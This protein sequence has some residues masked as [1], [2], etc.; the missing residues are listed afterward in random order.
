MVARFRNRRG[1][2]QALAKRLKRHLEKQDLEY[3]PI[4]LGLPRG[5]IIVGYEIAVA[6]QAPLDVCLVR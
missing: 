3:P 5:G 2:G 1:A 4:V 6:L